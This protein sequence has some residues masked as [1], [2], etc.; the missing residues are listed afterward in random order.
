MKWICLILLPLLVSSL[1]PAAPATVPATAPSAAPAVAV[2][3][4]IDDPAIPE[5][6]G[7]VASRRH[8]GVYWTHND[9]GNPPF[10]F[11]IDGKGKT[12]ARLPVD[13]ANV[14]WE[15]IAI[16]DSGH[17]F[18]ADTGNN[19][20]NRK[21]VFIYQFDEPDPAVK[22][23]GRPEPLPV[24]R[25]WTLAFPD[26]PFDCE[27]FFIHKGYGYV[28]SKL[29]SGERAT[30]YR[31]PLDP[32]LP[33]T[34]PT[35]IGAAIVLER[36]AD[37]PIRTPVTAADISADGRHLAVLSVAGL[38]IFEIN[39]DP[40]LAGRV[41]PQY[42]RH[43]DPTMEACCFVA[44]GVLAT[45]ERRQVLFFADA[46]IA[47]PP[48]PPE[49]LHL[50]I[51]RFDKSPTIDGDL[52]DWDVPRH[53]LVV[54]RDPPAPATA[55]ATQPA[56]VP[57]QIM[58]GWT[59][60]GLYLAGR[61]QTTELTPLRENW[62]TGDCAEIFIGRQSVDRPVEYTDADNRC[63]VGFARF[64][65][66]AWGPLQLHW[67][68]HRDK[69][70]ADARPA[71]RVNADGS[72]QFELFLPAGSLAPTPAWRQGGQLRLEVSLL[73]R[74]PRQ[75]FYLFTPDSRGCWLSPQTW[76]VVTLDP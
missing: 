23:A 24:K 47:H 9:S 5:S 16:D 19:S 62:F 12:I 66:G 61:I 65:G 30:L 6:S 29:L 58:A 25:K 70:L 48:A 49:P 69:P 3:G 28:I 15:D 75:N 13:A 39:G 54:H 38:S 63:Y 50:S 57:A 73:T 44:G 72:W 40:I 59:D 45:T 74:R 36:V 2:V 51:R 10:L 17:L 4:R 7:L 27:A 14:D 68:R 11:A 22:P 52:A 35:T 71:G 8:A 18:I 1:V 64:D 67:P 37:L 56:P 41:V 32:P 46:V 26:Q 60:Q 34:R 43:I 31:F 33:A 53:G 42:V 76:A 20:V 55:P 21:T